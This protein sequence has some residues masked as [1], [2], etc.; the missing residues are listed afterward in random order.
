MVCKIEHL[1]N[2]GDLKILILKLDV[3]IRNPEDTSR[4]LECPGMTTTS[5][6]LSETKP[7]GFLQ[8]VLNVFSQ[9]QA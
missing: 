5:G 2:K 3:N 6:L 4:L 1:K 7:K 8:G 9:I